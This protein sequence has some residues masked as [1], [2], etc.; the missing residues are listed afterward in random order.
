M[1]VCKPSGFFVS[2]SMKRRWSKLFVREGPNWADH[3]SGLREN[4]IRI[5]PNHSQIGFLAT[6]HY[7]YRAHYYGSRVL[8]FKMK[9]FLKKNS[10]FKMNCCKVRAISELHL[11]KSRYYRWQ[12]N[13]FICFLS[14]WICPIGM[15][16]T[17]IIFSSILDWWLIVCQ[18]DKKENQNINYE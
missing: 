3:W 5:N 16:W 18:Q 15:R 4:S 8:I 2:L 12:C 6:V 9:F 7:H 14:Y 1:T 17:S 13:N 10:C 11:Q